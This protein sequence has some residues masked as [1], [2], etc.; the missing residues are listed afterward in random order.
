MIMI[1]AE[2]GKINM[3]EYSH[4]SFPYPNVDFVRFDS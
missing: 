1:L 4:S 3:T 2:C